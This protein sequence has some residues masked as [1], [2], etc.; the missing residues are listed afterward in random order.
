MDKIFVQVRINKMVPE[1]GHEYNDALYYPFE[2]WP[3]KQEI[4]D[5]E[6]AR[7]IANWIDIVKNPPIQLEPTKKQLEKEL[8]DLLVQKSYINNQIQEKQLSISAMQIEK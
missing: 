6:K 8:S 3:I 1:I 5:A 7:R 4:I 2:E